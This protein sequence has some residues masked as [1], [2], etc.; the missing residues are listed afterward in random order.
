MPCD[1]L[2]SCHGTSGR[3]N[4]STHF[5][6]I[7]QSHD[8][9][10]RERQT[11]CYVA[12]GHTNNVIG[13]HICI[14]TMCDNHDLFEGAHAR[15]LRRLFHFAHE[16][17]IAVPRVCFCWPEAFVDSQVHVLAYCTVFHLLCVVKPN[18][19]PFVYI[20]N[21]QNEMGNSCPQ[22]GER[23][24]TSPPSPTPMEPPPCFCVA[25]VP[26]A[27]DPRGQEFAFHHQVL[28]SHWRDGPKCQMRAAVCVALR[29]ELNAVGC[30]KG[31]CRSVEGC[32]GALCRVCAGCVTWRG[33]WRVYARIVQGCGGCR[34]CSSGWA[35]M[36]CH[37]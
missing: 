28:H 16:L 2:F 7:V 20:Q 31:L 21:A 27:C 24:P 30:L 3:A 18:S 17:G 22:N 5:S 34:V 12:R 11:W 15:L 25:P 4:L 33:V 35:G 14:E 19:T 29:R 9:L 26:C 23:F 37:R 10:N 13:I 6:P 8:T 32:A 1:F 36:D